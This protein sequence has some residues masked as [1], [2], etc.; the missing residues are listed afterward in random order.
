LNNEKT[1]VKLC[2]KCCNSETPAPKST[3]TP[4]PPI[5]TVESP[6]ERTGNVK[7][8]TMYSDRIS[9]NSTGSYVQRLFKDILSSKKYQDFCDKKTENNNGDQDSDIEEEK[10]EVQEDEDVEEKEEEEP[11]EKTRIKNHFFSVNEEGQLVYSFPFAQ[12]SLFSETTTE[13]EKTEM[14]VEP[15]LTV[16]TTTTTDSKNPPSEGVMAGS[17]KQN[18]GIKEQF[19]KSLDELVASVKQLYYISSYQILKG[20]I[21]IYIHHC[22]DKV[23]NN[24]L[25]S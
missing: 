13:E 22:S 14:Q 21:Q 6:D 7:Y 25:F 1:N 11:E 20:L 9:T 12:K 24:I 16:T 23:P 17:G 5:V 18:K 3:P 19:D 10:E 4:K 2:G 8:H 15:S